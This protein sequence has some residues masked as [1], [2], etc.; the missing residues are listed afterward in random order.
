MV[1]AAMAV[2][3]AA[4]RPG[5]RRPAPVFGRGLPHRRARIRVARH[6]R[7]RC[8]LRVR[9]IH[10]VEVAG[11]RAHHGAP[12]PGE[13]TLRCLH[14]QPRRQVGLPAPVPCLQIPAPV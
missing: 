5:T 13:H 14:H 12:L 1:P 9:R 3:T 4:P 11:G 2:G 7:R 8:G 10:A 6:R